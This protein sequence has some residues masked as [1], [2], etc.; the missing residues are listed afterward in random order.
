MI[1]VP[2]GFSTDAASVPPAVKFYIDDDD[3]DILYAAV[4][5]DWLYFNHGFTDEGGRHN[6][7]DRKQA[8]EVLREAMLACGAPRFKTWVAWK[9]VRIFGGA[10]WKK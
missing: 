4:I 1:R 5:H 10:A 3:P 2:A 8:D 6:S 9:A 7:L